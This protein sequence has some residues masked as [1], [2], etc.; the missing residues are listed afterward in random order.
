MA[1]SYQS[2][3]VASAISNFQ[4]VPDEFDK[5]LTCFERAD[6]INGLTVEHMHLMNKAFQDSNCE[7]LGYLLEQILKQEE[8]RDE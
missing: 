7:Q 3:F 2:N 5:D 4:I 6:V 1:K 8:E